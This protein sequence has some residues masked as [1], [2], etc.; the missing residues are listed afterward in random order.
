MAYLLRRDAVGWRLSSFTDYDGSC[1]TLENGERVSKM[2]GWIA[3]PDNVRA[4]LSG[5]KTLLAPED[6]MLPAL[7]SADLLTAFQS[8]GYMLDSN[9]RIRKFMGPP[10]SKLSAEHIMALFVMH[11]SWH[12]DQNL[13]PE[14]KPMYTIWA[15]EP[16]VPGLLFP[17]HRMGLAVK[18]S[19]INPSFTEPQGEICII[20]DK[21]GW[22]QVVLKWQDWYAYPKAYRPEMNMCTLFVQKFLKGAVPVNADSIPTLLGSD[23]FLSHEGMMFNKG[24]FLTISIDDFLPKEGA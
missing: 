7:E 13:D 21:M 10:L 16:K 8:G 12:K 4:M 3:D 18:D 2:Q 23:K 22:R 19:E 15:V 17:D 1:F 24:G 11:L 9:W 14:N 6:M 20:T 5:A